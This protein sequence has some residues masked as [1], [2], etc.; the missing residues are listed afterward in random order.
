MEAPPPTDEELIAGI[1]AKNN[2]ALRLL[3]DRYRDM[4]RSICQRVM[5]SSADI[6][7]ALQ[8]VFIQVWERAQEYDPK[9]A[10]VAAWLTTIARRRTIDKLRRL[11]T[12]EQGLSKL[13]K[14]LLADPHAGVVD[15]AQDIERA[16]I[17]AFVAS[18][19]QTLPPP[20]Q[21]VVKLSFLD[22]MSQREIAVAVQAPLGTVKTRINLAMEKLASEAKALEIV[23]ANAKWRNRPS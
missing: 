8:D 15:G 10:K 11:I 14:T 9:K 20:Q 16:D 18:L 2:D 23:S 22:G 21:E 19:L 1:Q 6:D 5:P 7:E 12:H 13:S 4:L 3:Y 17:R